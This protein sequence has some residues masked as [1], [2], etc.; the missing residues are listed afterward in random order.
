MPA[1]HGSSAAGPL[2]SLHTAEN[3]GRVRRKQRM[4]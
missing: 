3:K 2:A 4:S 1:I